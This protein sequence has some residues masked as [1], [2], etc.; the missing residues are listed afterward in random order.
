LRNAFVAVY[1]AIPNKKVM[2]VIKFDGNSTAAIT[3]AENVNVKTN[4]TFPSQLKNF[5]FRSPPSRF[6]VG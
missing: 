3:N 6:F 4:I 5:I 1:P 2:R